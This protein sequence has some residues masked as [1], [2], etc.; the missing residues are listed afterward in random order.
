MFICGECAI[1]GDNVENL[2]LPITNHRSHAIETKSNDFHI[3]C[4]VGWLGIVINDF[5]ILVYVCLTEQVPANLT[6]TFQQVCQ[7]KRFFHLSYKQKWDAAHCSKQT[8]QILD[9]E[10]YC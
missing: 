6:V 8:H 2:L 4:Q 1:Q 9:A 3:I 10:Y 5:V 7:R